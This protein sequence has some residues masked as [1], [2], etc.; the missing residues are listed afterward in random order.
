MECKKSNGLHVNSMS[1][2][3]RPVTKKK[4]NAGN[5]LYLSL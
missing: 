4:L 5:L 2:V 3:V 1:N